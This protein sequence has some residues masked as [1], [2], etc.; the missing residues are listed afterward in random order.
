MIVKDIITILKNINV[1][2]SLGESELSTLAFSGEKISFT[3]G[4]LIVKTD[5]KKPKCIIILEGKA[6][7]Q[8][9]TGPIILKPGTVIGLLSLINNTK[10][11]N[12]IIAGSVGSALIINSDLFDNIINEFPEFS[13]IIR[14]YLTGKFNK[15][16]NSIEDTM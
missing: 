8:K 2:N 1:F 5:E 15:Q 13:L 14:D 10:P 7:I 12:A 9:K 6:Y 11:N 3:T 4:D 16:I